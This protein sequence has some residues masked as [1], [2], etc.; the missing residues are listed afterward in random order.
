MQSDISLGFYLHF[1]NDY[2]CWASLQVLLVICISPLKNS[3]CKSFDAAAAD[4]ELQQCFFL[5]EFWILAPYQIYD[6]QISSLFHKL[7]F[8][9]ADCA[10]SCIKVLKFDVV[11]VSILAFLVCS[12][13]VIS[14]KPSPRPMPINFPSFLLGYLQFQV[15]I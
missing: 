4:V 13:S 3:L 2:W 9:Y 8:H 6:L 15:H 1:L 12:L 10:F 7:P 11:H 5:N 14:T